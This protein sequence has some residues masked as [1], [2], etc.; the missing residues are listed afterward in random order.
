MLGKFLAPHE[1]KAYA[2]LRIISGLSFLMAGVPKVFPVVAGFP[3][4][5]VGSQIWIGGCI[6]IVAGLLITIGLFTVVAAFI[7]SGQ[8][9]VAY[10]QFHWKF[11]FDSNFLPTVNQGLA[12]LL[13][14][15]IFL[16]VACRGAGI[17]SVDGLRR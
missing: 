12:A 8:M 5:P 2:L 7:S 6:E 4:P 3:Q 16:A 17:W 14:C 11:Q 13:L 1:A 10:I 15:F 9:A